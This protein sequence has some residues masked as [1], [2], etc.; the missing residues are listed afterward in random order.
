M[1][2]HYWLRVHCCEDD[3]KRL[4]VLSCRGALS[5]GGKASSASTDFLQYQRQGPETPASEKC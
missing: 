4:E 5:A 2:K 1:Q 3:L